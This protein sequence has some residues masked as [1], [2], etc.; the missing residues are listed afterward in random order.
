[1]EKT[2]FLLVLLLIQMFPTKGSYSSVAV[3]AGAGGGGFGV[4]GGGGFG[5][6]GGGWWWRWRRFW[7]GGGTPNANTPDSSLTVAYKALQVWKSAI[8]SDPLKILDTWVGTN[9]CSY[10]GVFCANPR[11]G[12]QQPLLWQA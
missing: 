1:M 6:G 12:S 11:D 7:V 8:T 4:G 2:W 3:V 5:V 10:K 9:V